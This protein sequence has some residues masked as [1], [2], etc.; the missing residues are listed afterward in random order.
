MA[1]MIMAITVREPDS[2][3]HHEALSCRLERPPPLL[4]ASKPDWM[5]LFHA[6]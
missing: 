4:A 5:M 2:P 6:A 3:T 1:A